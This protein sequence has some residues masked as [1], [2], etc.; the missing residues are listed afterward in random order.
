M[1]VLVA[2]PE[3]REGDKKL[4]MQTGQHMLRAHGTPS[5]YRES[6]RVRAMLSYAP[7]AGTRT[8]PMTGTVATTMR[9]P[10]LQGGHGRLRFVGGPSLCALSLWPTERGSPCS[11]SPHR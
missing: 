4:P 6:P 11:P 5:T 9:Y 10:D 2:F 8:R 1:T 7:S 3:L